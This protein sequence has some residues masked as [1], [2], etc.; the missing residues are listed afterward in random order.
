MDK[1]FMQRFGAIG[2][3][4]ML[5]ASLGLASALQAQAAWG[6]VKR[7]TVSV[8]ITCNGVTKGKAV[9]GVAYQVDT[10][11]SLKRFVNSQSGYIS[12]IT[13]DNDSPYDLM[14]RTDQDDQVRFVTTDLGGTGW[15][16]YLPQSKANPG[17]SGGNAT[18]VDAFSF[19]N[20]LLNGQY[21]SSL[22]HGGDSPLASI[23]F[24]T[25]AEMKIVF[26]PWGKEGVNVNEMWPNTTSGAQL[27]AT[28]GVCT[29]AGDTKTATIT[30][31][32]S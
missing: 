18:V 2:A 4:L 24:S 23:P 12:G 13:L 32:N 21:W 14:I 15:S 25:I 20:F 16:F 31:P 26:G 7:L 22:T 30:L 9:F 8:P 29:G 3:V 28:G 19:Q 5:L 6:N 17:T 10:A 27:S 11:A 1:K